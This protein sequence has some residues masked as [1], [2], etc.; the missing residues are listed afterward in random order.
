MKHRS[1]QSDSKTE[2][3]IALAGRQWPTRRMTSAAGLVFQ[4]PLGINLRGENATG[5]ERWAVTYQQ[6]VFGRKSYEGGGLVAALPQ[7]VSELERR[8]EAKALAESESA[9]HPTDEDPFGVPGIK[10]MAFNVNSGSILVDVHFNAGRKRFSLPVRVTDVMFRKRLRDCWAL[11][12]ALRRWADRLLE[13]ADYESILK[14]SIETPPSEVVQKSAD[15]LLSDDSL[16]RIERYIHEKIAAF[17]ERRNVKPKRSRGTT[18]LTESRSDA[19]EVPTAN[20]RPQPGGDRNEKR[21]DRFGRRINSTSM[22]AFPPGAPLSLGGKQVSTRR[23]EI[24]PGE[25]VTVPSGI[26]LR[27][28]RNGTLTWYLPP[29]SSSCGGSRR[30]AGFWCSADVPEGLPQA[31][32]ALER[33]KVG[34]RISDRPTTDSARAVNRRPCIRQEMIEAPQVNIGGRACPARLV[35]AANGEVYTVPYGINLQRETQDNECWCVALRVELFPRKYFDKPNMQV[36]LQSAIAELA[37]R[38]D[39]LDRLRQS[40]KEAPVVPT[41]RCPFGRLG[42]NFTAANLSSGVLQMRVR[43]LG[44]RRSLGMALRLTD[45]LFRNRLREAWALAVAARDWA[46]ACIASGR[47]E[48]LD[49]L[50]LDA[51]PE[52]VEAAAQRVVINDDD[53]NTAEEMIRE[54]IARFRAR[55]NLSP[56]RAS[57]PP[58]DYLMQA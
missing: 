3:R 34:R 32:A 54:E 42:I 16:E 31:I 17:R 8:L 38:L 43:Y 56:K 35:T 20:R 10:F 9:I 57:S 37:Q 48:E 2:G 49:R 46:D 30:Q 26:G 12:V 40:L 5:R 21:L 7:A 39:E 55:K 36:A 27:E 47:L 24:R 6:T 58:T 33:R 22:A 41:A 4:V 11:A 19:L 23:V 51:I 44:R 25:V 28:N 1:V 45:C 14:A 52:A 15:Y 18:L 29:A 53:L 13:E 50:A